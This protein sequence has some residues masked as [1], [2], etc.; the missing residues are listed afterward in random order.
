MLPF[1]ELMKN[2]C[3]LGQDV[4]FTKPTSLKRTAQSNTVSAFSTHIKITP[5]FG[6]NYQEN[7]IPL[8]VAA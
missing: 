4:R 3:P 7:E 2:L 5:T 1:W 6:E 8:D